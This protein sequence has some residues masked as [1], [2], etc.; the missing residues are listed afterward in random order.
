MSHIESIQN[1][2]GSIEEIFV[3]IV[4]FI[5]RFSVRGCKLLCGQKYFS[6][7]CD[8][9]NYKITKKNAQKNFHQCQMRFFA[10]KCIKNIFKMQKR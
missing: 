7:F 3:S 8:L 2:G 1:I 4:S 9:Q 10:K 5:F 6:I